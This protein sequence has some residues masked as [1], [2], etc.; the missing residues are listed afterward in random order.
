MKTQI[1]TV[2][3]KSGLKISLEDAN[4]YQYIQRY[5]VELSEKAFPVVDSDALDWSGTPSR[6]TVNYLQIEKGDRIIEIVEDEIACIDY[7]RIKTEEI[8]LE[9]EEGEII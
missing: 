3:L 5:R 8:S 4:R 1:K 2:W 6:I 9:K 7:I